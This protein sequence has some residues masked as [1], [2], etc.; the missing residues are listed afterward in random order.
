MCSK[1]N[2]TDTTSSGCSACNS[3]WNPVGANCVPN[4]TNGY[5]LHNKTPDLGGTLAVSSPYA[6]NACGP[7]SLYGWLSNSVLTVT[8]PGIT[9]SF[10]QMI[11]YFGIL[12]TDSRRNSIGSNNYWNIYTSFSLDF[13]TG[14]SSNSYSYRGSL[15]YVQKEYYC[16]RDSRYEQW[17][18]IS[19]SY[20][21]GTPNV[22]LS[23]NIYNN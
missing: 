23:F 9:V 8:S 20:S 12:T 22:S 3:Y 18:K 17:N 6:T 5:Y 1:K 13:V 15:T 7:Y 16:Y 11:V 10:Y 14:G 4:S 21:F 19:Q 2:C